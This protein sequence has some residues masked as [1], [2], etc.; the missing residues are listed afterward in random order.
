MPA[1][2]RHD[3]D[4]ARPEAG[5]TLRHLDGQRARQDV[6]QLVGVGV[7]VPRELAVDLDH[8]DVVVVDDGDGQRLPRLVDRVEH[9][10][11]IH[12]L[13]HAPS[14]HRGGSG[15]GGYQDPES[16]G[17]SKRS[18]VVNDSTGSRRNFVTW[19][20]GHAEEDR[21]GQGV[22][23]GEAELTGGR[24]LGAGEERR[25]HA[26]EAVGPGGEQDA[27][28]E[29]V[30]RRPAG[31]R[32]PFEPAVHEGDLAQVGGDGEDDWDVGDVVEQGEGHGNRRGPVPGRRR[33]CTASCRARRGR[34]SR[35]TPVASGRRA[36]RGRRVP[37]D[38]DPP[39]LAVA[40]A[41][42]EAGVV[43]DGVDDGRPR[44]ARP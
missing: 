3:V 34:R 2:A 42:R 19:R 44:P 26:T 16:G 12:R 27:P 9:R 18:T 6:E 13:V 22:V 15:P 20:S 5:V 30:D 29:R 1:A 40:A 35:P 10:L 11:Q 41:R 37:D 4:V 21:R 17:P 7:A 25:H 33:S 28:A 36:A 8:A 39:R 32:W 38:G 24:R 31:E 43:E 14:S 23:L